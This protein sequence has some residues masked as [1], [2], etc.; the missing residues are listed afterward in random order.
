MYKKCL[1][2]LTLNQYKFITGNDFNKNCFETPILYFGNDKSLKI[3]RNFL[4]KYYN[5]SINNFCSK[6]NLYSQDIF[7]ETYYIDKENKIK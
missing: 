7:N 4:N 6:K 5:I 3:N 1:K 2:Y